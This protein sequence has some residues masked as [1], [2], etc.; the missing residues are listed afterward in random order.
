[1]LDWNDF[2]LLCFVLFLPSSIRCIRDWIERGQPPVLKAMQL[3]F[4]FLVFGC[5]KSTK[6]KA[7]VYKLG[8]K[9]EK[10]EAKRD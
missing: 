7:D 5:L 4:Q 10:P 6:E 2:G 9:I 1:M 3:L 8:Q